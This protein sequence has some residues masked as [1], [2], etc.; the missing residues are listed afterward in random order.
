M[1]QHFEPLG[2]YARGFIDSAQ[3][4]FERAD[5]PRG[6]V[7]FAFYPAAYC[8]RHGIELFVKQMCIYTAYEAEDPQLL[9]APSHDLKQ[10]WDAIRGNVE[11]NAYEAGRSLDCWGEQNMREHFESVELAIENL[12][13]MDPSGQLFRYPERLKI[14]KKQGT[15]TRTTQSPP[16]EAVDLGAWGTVCAN[17]LEAVTMLLAHAEEVVSDLARRRGHLPL[18]FHDLVMGISQPETSHDAT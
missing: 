10:N 5:E 8:L 14:N 11:N 2:I 15:R 17:C 3:A 16:F 4:L 13:L 1:N 12:H 7:D 9:Y 18:D 6:L